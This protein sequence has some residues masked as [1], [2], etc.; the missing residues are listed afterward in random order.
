MTAADESTAYCVTDLLEE[1]GFGHLAEAYRDLHSMREVVRRIEALLAVEFPGVDFKVSAS[2]T[3][4]NTM[5]GSWFVSCQW[6]NLPSSERCVGTNTA[7]STDPVSRFAEYCLPELRGK[8][9]RA[10]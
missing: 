2:V 9:R 7:F 5:A 10:Q 8:M 6:G 3:V 1:N 4:W